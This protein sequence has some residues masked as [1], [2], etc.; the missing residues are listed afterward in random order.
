MHWLKQMEPKSYHQLQKTYTSSL[1]KLLFS[2]ISDLILVRHLL[3]FK[4]GR[5]GSWIR[6]PGRVRNFSARSDPD[7]EK[8]YR[9]RIRIWLFWQ[10]NLKVFANFPS[11]C[12]NF[13][14]I[15]YIIFLK[16]LTTLNSLAAVPLCTRKIC[17]L[18][19]FCLAWF[20]GWMWVVND[21]KSRIP[22]IQRDGWL[23]RG[24]GG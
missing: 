19:V 7:L 15:A 23:S 11:K 14:L 13:S 22:R 3:Y 10:E 9:I 21:L 12:P 5:A 1:G 8:M 16:I 24:M 20:N 18:P 4:S 6:I 2:L 17:R